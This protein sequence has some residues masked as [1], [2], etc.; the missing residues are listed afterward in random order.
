MTGGGATHAWADIFVPGAGWVEFDPTNR[1]FE[2]RNRIRVAKTRTPAQALPVVGTFVPGGGRLLGLQ[3]AVR[4]TR[5]D[6]AAVA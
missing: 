4:V 3:V 2:S 5:L 1:I 6:E